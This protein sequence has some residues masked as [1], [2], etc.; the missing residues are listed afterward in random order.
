[1]S[2]N[3]F[4]QRFAIIALNTQESRRL[5]NAKKVSLRCMAAGI[6]LE[7]Y[8]NH[9]FEQKENQLDLD[10]KKIDNQ[11]S[12]YQR[13]VFK[14]LFKKNDTFTSLLEKVTKLS[15]KS[16]KEI[17]NAFVTSLKDL[18]LIIET[19]SLLSCDLEFETAGIKV[20]EYRADTNVYKQ[21][22]DKIRME[23]L[24]KD[25]KSDETILMM[26]LLKE[27]SC[28][29]DLFSEEELNILAN[30]YNELLQEHALAKEVFHINIHKTREKF[31]KSFLKTK[32]KIISTPEGSGVNFIFPYIERSQ[33]VFIDT[34][35]Y[36]ENK[37]ERLRDVKRRLNKHNISH[38]FIRK[39]DVPLI[40][41]GNTYYEAVPFS[42]IYRMPVHGVQLRRYPLS[43]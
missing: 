17:E 27:S 31:I 16:L 22:T 21:L 10:R 18:D 29:Y 5:T 35:T 23:L 24:N 39:G 3:S 4:S 14:K 30:S 40:Q 6:I 43:I 38:T 7:M 34:E 33:A 42:K 26:W 15:S 12:P 8:L 37:E 28:L 41:I 20:K 9:F 2:V 11:L 25:L 32:R 1:M 13:V 19:P 36:F